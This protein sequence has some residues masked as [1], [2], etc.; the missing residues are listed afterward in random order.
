MR[1]SRT[2]ALL[3]AG[4]VLTAAALSANELRKG[5]S[6]YLASL[7]ERSLKKAFPARSVRLLEVA[8]GP[9]RAAAAKAILARLERGDLGRRL[10]LADLK[11]RTADRRVLSFLGEAGYLDVMADGSKLRVRGAIDD[12]KEI[13]RAGAGRI[14]KKALEDLGRRFVREALSPLVKL[15]KGETLMFLGVRYLYDGEAGTEAATASQERERVIASIAIFGREVAGLPIVG[16][17][18]K[19]AVWFDNSREPVGF[20]VDWPVYRV[21]SRVQRVLSQAE[22]ARRIATTTVPLG[23]TKDITVRRFECGYVDLGATRRTKVM[24]AGCSIA[25][26]G[27]G[28]G[29]EVWGR[30]EFV[31]AGRPALKEARWPLA[32]AL[33]AGDVIN[34]GTEEF[35]RF[36]NSP[37]AP[38]EAPPTAQ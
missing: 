31:P 5:H 11:P 26:E 20:D 13:E 7:T 10:R 3:T 24:Q 18:S 23:G 2:A 15:G 8:P 28:E 21:S 36:L 33:A 6:D 12:T 14:E 16:S 29:G 34:T 1:I 17:G 25:F 30:T 4:F 27:R 9:G 38:D 37:K 22:L 32:N 19:V 35:Q